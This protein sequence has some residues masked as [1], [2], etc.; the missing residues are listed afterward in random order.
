MHNGNK[1]NLASNMSLSRNITFINNLSKKKVKSTL[2][3]F[4]KELAPTLRDEH[5]LKADGT[6]NF[7]EIC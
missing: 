1:E 5:S 6:T 7:L 3:L 4:S 2:A